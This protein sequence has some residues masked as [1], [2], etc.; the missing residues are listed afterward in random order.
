MNYGL[1][2][3]NPDGTIDVNIKSTTCNLKVE[4]ADIKTYDKL[5]VSIEDINT[6]DKLNV[7]VDK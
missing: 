7:K 1:V 5:N 6:S 4:L 2:P 3:I